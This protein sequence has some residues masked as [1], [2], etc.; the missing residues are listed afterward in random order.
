MRRERASDDSGGLTLRRLDRRVARMTQEC[1]TTSMT[2]PTW[3]ELASH[4]ELRCA[5]R[6]ISVEEIER[7]IVERHHQRRKNPGLADWR[8]ATSRL[9]VLYDWPI[10]GDPTRALVRTAWRR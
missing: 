1:L 8:V 7:V 10:G 5:K 9:V 4:L 6:G 2:G 3:I